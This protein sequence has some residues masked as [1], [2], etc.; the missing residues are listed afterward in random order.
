MKYQFQFAGANVG[1]RSAPQKSRL[2]MAI[3]A[4][5]LILAALA[6]ANYV[7][8]IFHLPFNRTKVVAAARPVAATAVAT[9]PAIPAAKGSDQLPT[10][11]K[12]ATD[13]GVAAVGSAVAKTLTAA[14]VAPVATT[15]A[16]PVTE[17]PAM[18]APIAAVPIAAAP[19]EDLTK[20]R[21]VSITTVPAVQIVQPGSPVPASRPVKERT[22]QDRLE[23]AGQAAFQQAMDLATKYPDAYGLRAE[24][25]L[26][27][28]VL[29]APMPIYTIEEAD[30]AKYMHG[31]SVKPILKEAKQWI[32][33][34][35]INN[36]VCCMVQVTYTGRDYV[37]NKG[38][39]LLGEA[40][41]K[42]EARWPASEGYHPMIVVNPDVP[43]FY[44]TIPE[45]PEP[46]MTDVVRLF[47][48]NTHL[49]PADVI[50]ASWR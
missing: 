33:P 35:T 40:W 18:P 42:I 2:R 45:L 46:N 38:S 3:L 10:A 17:A 30:R 24:D 12:N 39:K 16:A 9:A 36:R 21:V 28:A 20:P 27:D 8:N 31:E 34:V 26:A 13:A 14:P 44:F 29:G 50:L 49:S 41:N 15:V 4:A 25:A 43:G 5:G 47:E 1:R 22:P 7:F 48:F 37:P 11:L 6:Y 19:V 23:I 32:F